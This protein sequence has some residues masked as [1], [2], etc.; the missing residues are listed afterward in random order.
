[1]HAAELRQ[2][3]RLDCELIEAHAHGL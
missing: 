2:R 3:G 1:L